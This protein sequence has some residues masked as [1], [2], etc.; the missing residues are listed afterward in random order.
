M[1]RRWH[2]EIEPSAPPPNTPKFQRK[3]QSHWSFL[4]WGD[5]AGAGV[6]TAYASVFLAT[7]SIWSIFWVV[8]VG[9]GLCAWVNV[10]MNRWQRFLPHG[11]ARSAGGASPPDC[12]EPQGTPLR[13]LTGS[14]LWWVQ[15]VGRREHAA[16]LI[17]Y[18]IIAAIT[19]ALAAFVPSPVYWAAGIFT[20]GWSLY[21]GAI[22][23]LYLRQR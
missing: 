10:Q 12:T 7:H 14:R 8:L 9:G 23:L 4:R 6:C 15:P 17:S 16:F 1:D 20:S 19:L 3:L 22:V 18:L 11:R 5:V 13:H 2:D 21:I